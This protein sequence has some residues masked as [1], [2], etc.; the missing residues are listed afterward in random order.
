[1]PGANEGNND[2]A[3]VASPFPPSLSSQKLSPFF[4]EC[5]AGAPYETLS[6]Q[7]TPNKENERNRS[8]TNKRKDTDGLSSNELDGQE[9]TQLS[10]D[11]D[12]EASIS[13]KPAPG[14][15][16]ASVTTGTSKRTKRS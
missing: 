16:S 10:Q 13:S 4:G 1:M 14:P 5:L 3:L 7:G 6:P 8:R 11:D 15:V 2:G 9:T 12:M